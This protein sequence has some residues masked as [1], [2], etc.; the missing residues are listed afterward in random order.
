MVRHLLL[1]ACAAGF[2]LASTVVKRQ[3]Q[4][5]SVNLS[6]MQG[7]PQHFASGFLYGIPDTPNQIPAH[8]YSEIAFNYGR[9]GGAQLP[10]KGYMDGIEEYRVCQQ[11]LQA[12][13]L[14]TI[15]S[16]VLL[17]CYPI[18]I[19]AASS[20]PSSLSSFMIYGEPMDQNPSPTSFLGITEIGVH[21]T[22]FLTK[23]SLICEPII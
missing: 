19:L 13:S 6:Q 16:L 12:R 18:I 5:A 3:S 1:V 4:T 17:Q 15:Y 14:L 2:S 9:A 23:L 22:T 21:G 7:A 8:F 10:A 20:V 11:P